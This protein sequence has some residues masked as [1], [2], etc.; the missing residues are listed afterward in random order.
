MEKLLFRSITLIVSPYHVGLP[1]IAVAN[2]PAHLKH[3]GLL[4]SIKSINVPVQEIEIPSV[5]ASVDGE[6][7]RS[8]ELIR[9][10]SKLVSQ[11]H[12]QRSFPIILAGNCSAGVGGAAGLTGVTKSLGKQLACVWFDAHDDFNTPETM[13]SGYFDSMPIAMMGGL[14][15][16]SMLASVPGHQPLDLNR[17]VHVGMRDVNDIERKHVENEGLSVVWGSLD[18]KVDFD[19]GL[20]RFLDEKNLASQP[21]YVHFDVDSIDTSIGKANRFA[22]PGGL[23]QEDVVRCM[24]RI[25][26]QTTPLA[27]TIASFDPSFEGA[28]AIADVA[29]RGLASFLCS[30]KDDG[31]FVTVD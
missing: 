8:F 23:L 1:R 30:M 28:D 27:F 29:I 22:A 26:R 4:D 12:A 11:A 9:Q 2:G 7:G 25:A 20:A 21:V 15:F 10:T 17:L 16:K 5:E 24:Q 14:C 19:E 31:M 6:I 18:R 13:T 3:R